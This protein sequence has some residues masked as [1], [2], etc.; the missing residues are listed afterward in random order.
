MFVA[1]L[2]LGCGSSEA[3]DNP[4]SDGGTEP[5]LPPRICKSPVDH[6][7]PWFTD[8]TAEIG[9]AATPALE[10]LANTFVSADLDG[11][12]WP[13]L[14]ASRGESAR[15]LIDG[16]RA[17]FLFM[18]RPSQTQPDERVLEDRPDL[19]G[20][21][22]T[23]DGGSDRGF[24]MA[25]LGDLNNDGSTDVI[26]CPS[27]FGQLTSL[28]D[29]CAAFLN[30]GSG[31]FT[32]AGDI[33]P[34]HPAT[35]AVL[36]DF[37]RDGILDLFVPG[38]ARWPNPSEKAWSFGPRL[39]R[40]RG[41]GSFENV[42][43]EV[44]LPQTEGFVL[45]STA[46]RATLG[47]TSCDL[48]G[49]GDQD[50][51]LATYGRKPNQVYRNDGGQLVEV[52]ALLGLAHDDREDYS[53]DESYRCYCKVTGKCEPAPPLPKVDCNAFGQ[54]YF[55]GWAPNISDKPYSLG[56]NDMGVTCGDID[57]DG[58]MDVS[59]ATIVHGDVGSSS[60]P[61]E[62]ILNPGD[63]GRFTRPGNELTGLL[64]PPLT[65]G[66]DHGDHMIVYAD[67][68][69]DGRKDVWVA[70]IVYPGTHQWLWRQKPD[71]RFEEFTVQSGLHQPGDP[72]VMGVT[73]ADFDGDGDLDLVTG[74]YTADRSVRV[75]RNVVGDRSN[76]VRIKLVGK[77]A[78]FSN[79]SAIGARV[80]VS[81][82]GRAQ[83]QEVRGGQGLSNVQNDLVLGFGLGDACEIDEIE[84]R[85]PDAEST[86]THYASVRA[87]YTVVL[88][89]GNP[90]PE[91]R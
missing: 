73:L 44:G 24:S 61:T 7:L 37:D 35:S 32:L 77:G 68:D 3:E 17:R 5:D 47:A 22:A 45:D 18:N 64:R 84:V 81:A 34:D 58:D 39:F 86:V 60:D 90:T 6:D 23:R 82:G 56:G 83:I 54:P 15:G 78:G 59:F 79:A 11:D 41:D 69:L 53:D 48:D 25:L 71:G 74:R 21:G 87:N 30:D 10:P 75:Y 91:Y 52:G 19:N 33:D 14:L 63:G 1:L 80:R 36:V 8:A 72:A 85:W 46:W 42:S 62:L 50:F 49:D 70:S 12:G 43:A 27:D 76:F 29:P 67:L 26:T 4:R 40:G 57:D 55:R 31:Q 66:S 89:E 28:A 2:A 20:L 51:L 9:L 65:P 13:D 88:R 38:I 16:K